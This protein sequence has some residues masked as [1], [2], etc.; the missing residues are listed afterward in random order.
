MVDNIRAVN[1]ANEI[2]EEPFA[3]QTGMFVVPELERF[4]CVGCQPAGRCRVGLQLHSASAGGPVTGT[5][6]FGPEHEG[7]GG[8]AHGGS[9]MTAFD[10]ICGGVPLSAGVLA[11]TAELTTHFVR[12]VPVGE[13]LEISAKAEHRDDRGRWSITAEIRLPGVDTSLARAHAQFVER[14]PRR[15]YGRFREWLSQRT[16]GAGAS[17]RDHHR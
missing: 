6:K 8:V 10:E 11:V 4:L 2:P 12:P 13:H 15:H 9:V 1:V 3:E 17:D 7:A 16:D 5:L 14:D